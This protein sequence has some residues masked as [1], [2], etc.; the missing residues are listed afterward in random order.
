MKKKIKENILEI[1]KNYK[2]ILEERY[3]ENE[4]LI[5]EYRWKMWEHHVYEGEEKQKEI[6]EMFKI[7]KEV[8]EYLKNEK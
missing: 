5:G 7:I 1:I 2:S 4:K 6:K 8:R 3:E